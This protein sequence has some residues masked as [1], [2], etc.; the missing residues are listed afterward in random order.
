MRGMDHEGHDHANE[1]ADHKHD[2]GH[3]HGAE[4]AAAHSDEIY[5]RRPKRRLPE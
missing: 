1:G 5:C 3:D 2:D 4:A